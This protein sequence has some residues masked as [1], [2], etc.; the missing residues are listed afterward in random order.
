MSDQQPAIRVKDG[1]RGTGCSGP[2][3]KS[4]RGLD[5]INFLMA[6]VRDGVGPYLSVFLKGGQHWEPGAI[7][8]AMAASSLAAA[9]CQIPAG[10]LVDSLKSKRLLVAVSGL[11]VAAGCLLVAVYPRFLVVIGAQ[12][13]LGAASAIIPPAIAAISLGLVRRKMLDR[14]ISRIESF[15]H[16]GN[17][18]AAALAGGLGQ[19]LGYQWIFYLVCAFAIASAAV[20]TLINPREID[21]EIARGGETRDEKP[22]PL[23]DL[24]RRRDLLTFLVSVILFHFGNAAMLP[25]A[26]QVLAQTHPGSDAITL[27]ACIIAAQFVMIGVAWGVGTAVTAGYGRKTI[28][29]L[30]LAVL[31]IRGLLFSFTSNPYGV[32][33]IQ[34]LDGV[35]AGIFGVI[36]ILIASDLMHGTGRFNFAQGLVALCVGVGAGLIN[37]ISGFVVQYFGYPVGF[38]FLATIALAALVFFA[39]MMPETSGRGE[40]VQPSGRRKTIFSDAT[41]R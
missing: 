31:P 15:N 37:L 21:H 10:L 38:L 16:G 25:M 5:G 19:Y 17:F 11:L 3:L 33:A 7:G 12:I 24:L 27:S 35:A 32:V 39:L 13:M 22:A 4:L 40:S 9:L 36:A 1:S 34:L 14:R 30:A 28:F 29:L 18:A 8:I 23:R 26:G 20:I 41:A 6:D 2:S